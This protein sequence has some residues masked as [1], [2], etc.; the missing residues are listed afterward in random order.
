MRP[1]TV[2]RAAAL[3]F[4][5]Q[6]HRRLPAVQ[7]AMWCVSVRRG[8]EIVGVALVGWPSQEQT[9]DEMDHLRVLRVAVK[10]GN[11]NACSMLYGA[12]WRAARAM[13][14]TSM[15]THTHADEYSASVRAAG[16]VYGGMTSGGEHSR[17]TRPRK[18]AIDP[19]PKH[20]WWAPGSLKAPQPPRVFTLADWAAQATDTTTSVGKEEQ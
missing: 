1:W 16:W 18:A 17:A 19:R 9:T 15:D 14:V 5:R 2:K 13:G 3:E 11:P 12:A 6:V 20:R 7:G 8:D 10:E 4:V